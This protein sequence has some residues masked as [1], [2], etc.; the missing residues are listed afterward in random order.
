MSSERNQC[1]D[2][3]NKTKNVFC[4]QLS[5]MYKAYF[6]NKNLIQNNDF[7]SEIIFTYHMIQYGNSLFCHSRWKM[8]DH[9]ID[10]I[11]FKNINELEQFYDNLI[12]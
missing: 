11:N 5:N 7:T 10:N 3:N 12:Y 1:L 4:L 6:S 2:K 9:T 8:I